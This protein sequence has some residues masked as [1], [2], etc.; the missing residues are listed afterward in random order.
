MTKKALYVVFLFMF[1][2]QVYSQSKN[3]SL[4]VNFRL[5]F[6][7]LPLELNKKYISTNKDTLTIE[8]FKCYISNIQVQ[9]SDK[10]VFIPKNSY[11]LLDSNNPASFEIPVT[12]K[13]N[14]MIS[15]ITFDIGIDSLTNTSGALS[16]ALDPVNGMYWTWQSG[17]INMKI[18]GSS[19]SCKTRKNE[20]QF[21]IGGYLQPNYALQ[22]IKLEWDKKADSDINIAIDLNSFFSNLELRETNSVMNPGKEAM[23]LAGFATKMFYVR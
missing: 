12:K 1:C 8:T 22:Q 4:Y 17:Y 21:H 18:E 20:F 15:R 19:P 11:H 13:G 23:K 7:K 14:K 16:G 3:D 10:S 6:N 2:F 5:E 9:Y